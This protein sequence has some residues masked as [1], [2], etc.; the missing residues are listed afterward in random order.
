MCR[1]PN[2]GRT[3]VLGG[4]IFDNRV[5]PYNQYLALRYSGHLNVEI[6]GMIQAVK[7]MYK[8]VYK[9]PDRATLRMIRNQNGFDKRVVDEI[10][11]FVT[12]LYVCAPE[13][14][15]ILLEFDRQ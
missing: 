15:Y 11:E 10:D 1:R 14:V 7:Y 6:C 3:C 9:G 4:K 13:A 2:D 5:V 8:Y 12:A